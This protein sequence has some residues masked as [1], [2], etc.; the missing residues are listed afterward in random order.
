MFYQT[1]GEVNQLGGVFVNGRPLPNAIRLRIVELAQLGIRP[2]DIS[3]QLR[4]SHGCVSKILARYNET[5]SILPGAIGGSK[6]RVTTP[7]VVKYIREYKQGDPGIFAWEIRDRLLGDAVCDKYNVPS[8]SSISRILRNK[9]GNLSHSGH[10]E[11]SKQLP[12]QHTLPYNPIYQYSYPNHM[13]SAAA[14]MGSATGVPVPGVTGHMGIHRTW[15]SA[16]SVSNI[17]GLRSIVEQAA[18]YG[19]SEVS[20]YQTKME[21]WSNVNRAAF[22]SAQSVNGIEKQAIDPDLKY[23]QP[24]S[25]LSAASSFVP[26]CAVGPYPSS[27]QVPGYG[28]YSGP[29]AGYVTGHPWQSQGSSLSHSG[30]GIGMHGGDIHAPMPFK[31]L[32]AREVADRKPGNPANKPSESHSNPHGLSIP[33]SST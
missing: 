3:R 27:N 20:A 17:L 14:K 22:S 13:S 1:Y 4:V 32:A 26:A 28:V 30:P 5:G 24:P 29:G 18:A 2:C 8:V 21:D 19:G 6:P 9:I 16:H 12:S 25:A 31:H 23:P 11:A 7:T 15:P 10:Y 33:A